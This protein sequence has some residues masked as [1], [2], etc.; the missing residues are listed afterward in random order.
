MRNNA[1]NLSRMTDD[2]VFLHTVVAELLSMPSG[3]TLTWHQHSRDVLMPLLKLLQPAQLLSDLH[4]PEADGLQLSNVEVTRLIED[5]EHIPIPIFAQNRAYTPPRPYVTIKKLLADEHHDRN[6]S[7]DV[8]IASDAAGSGPQSKTIAQIRRRFVDKEPKADPWNV[9]GCCKPGE[10]PLPEFLD[11]LDYELLPDVTQRAIGFATRARRD[12]KQDA[13]ED[14]EVWK[15]SL[16]WFLLAEAGALTTTHQD[17]LGLGTWISCHQGE[18]GFAWLSRPSEKETRCWQMDPD[19]FHGGNWRFKVLR[20]GET[21][22][23]DPGLIHFVFRQ[24][25]DEQQTLAFG[26][27]SFRRSI[28]GTWARIFDG[29]VA[30]VTTKDITALET[31]K[32]IFPWNEDLSYVLRYGMELLE[33]VETLLKEGFSLDPHE[34]SMF[35]E[36]HQ[37][38]LARFKSFRRVEDALERADDVR[39]CYAQQDRNALV[40]YQDQQHA[41]DERQVVASPRPESK[42]RRKNDSADIVSFVEPQPGNAAQQSKKQHPKKARPDN[43]ISIAVMDRNSNTRTE[44]GSERWQIDG[45]G[46]IAEVYT[47]GRREEEQETNGRN[48]ELAAMERICSVGVARIQPCWRR[49][50]KATPPGPLYTLVAHEN[51]VLSIELQSLKWRIVAPVMSSSVGIDVGGKMIGR[52]VAMSEAFAIFCICDLRSRDVAFKEQRAAVHHSTD[53]RR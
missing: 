23:F 3:R 29:H 16:S 50:K 45:D 20:P 24:S 1:D 18:I 21:V 8:Q 34:A 53:R 15:R 36:Y 37:R 9:L 28:A 2:M 11:G 10:C 42:R 6:V 5:S 7:L 51:R 41:S 35:R 14:V 30:L 43:E 47:K 12:E 4:D 32:T 38:L 13:E 25:G 44:R 31:R 52:R 17:A 49:S 48:L 39:E 22:Y 26:G 33:A 46:T 27:H 19:R 40:E